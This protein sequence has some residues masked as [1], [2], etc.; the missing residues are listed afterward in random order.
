MKTKTTIALIAL[1]LASAALFTSCTTVIDPS[2]APVTT[3]QQATTTSTQQD[4][5]T[6][7]TTYKKTT[8]TNY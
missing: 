7:S 4:P 1:A 2:P 8:T 3:T 6:G 5:Y